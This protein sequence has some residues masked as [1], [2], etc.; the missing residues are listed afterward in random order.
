[1]TLQMALKYII[2]E[3]FSQD[4]GTDCGNL[5]KT[6]RLNSYADLQINCKMV[7]VS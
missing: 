5:S 7:N 4:L 3:V 1:M 6:R 2:L